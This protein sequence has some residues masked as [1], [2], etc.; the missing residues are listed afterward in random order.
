M[1]WEQALSLFRE[2]QE[3]LAADAVAWSSILTACSDVWEVA[4]HLLGSMPRRHGGISSSKGPTRPDTVCVNAA[5]SAC[6][7]SKACR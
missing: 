1:A 7:A 6:A 5:L 4:C 2:L 3:R